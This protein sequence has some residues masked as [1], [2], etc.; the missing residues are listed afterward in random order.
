MLDQMHGCNCTKHNTQTN[1][2]SNNNGAAAHS[3]HHATTST[4]LT[5]H[6]H[7]TLTQHASPSPEFFRLLLLPP[8]SLS[9]CS[10]VWVGLDVNLAGTRRG[11]HTQTQTQTRW[12]FF[13]PLPWQRFQIRGVW[14]VFGLIWREDGAGGCELCGGFSVGCQRGAGVGILGRGIRRIS[15][16]FEL[17]INQ[18]LLLN[19]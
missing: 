8:Y 9:V 3:N 2:Q 17:N 1:K 7:N 11:S 16:K 12:F 5:A 10:T 18:V 6:T 19:F 4:S 14:R 13:P 15:M